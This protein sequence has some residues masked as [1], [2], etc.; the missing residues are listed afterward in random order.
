MKKNVLVWLCAVIVIITAFGGKNGI[1]TA[2]AQS[3]AVKSTVKA[4]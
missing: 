4:S 2:Y 1:S 3:Q